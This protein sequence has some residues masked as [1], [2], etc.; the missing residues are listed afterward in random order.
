MTLI[1]KLTYAQRLLYSVEKEHIRIVK[2]S[3]DE[4]LKWRLRRTKDD[5]EEHIDNA[6]ESLH[7]WLET[8]GYFPK[9]H[10]TL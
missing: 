8:I 10:E 1:D 9:F 4:S 2:T 5:A 3:N 6:I 7:Y